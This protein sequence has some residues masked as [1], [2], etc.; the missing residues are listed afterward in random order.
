MSSVV[1][2]DTNVLVIEPDETF[3]A[4]VRAALPSHHFCVETAANGT[5]AWMIL[6]TFKHEFDLI[7][8]DLSLPDLDGLELLAKIRRSPKNRAT[9]VVICTE[10]THRDEVAAAIRHG[11]RQ[12]VVKPCAAESLAQKILGLVAHAHP[13]P[14]AV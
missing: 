5:D 3:S 1:P 10:R 7:V 4:A 8:L 2:P 13:A 14:V 11:V 6:A 12:Y 9:P